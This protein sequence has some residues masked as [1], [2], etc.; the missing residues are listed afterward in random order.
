MTIALADVPKIADSSIKKFYI[1]DGKRRIQTDSGFMMLPS[2]MSRLMFGK[3]KG[4][5]Y[6]QR[7]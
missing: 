7:Q 1:K 3:M 2:G 4:G 5:K 6:S